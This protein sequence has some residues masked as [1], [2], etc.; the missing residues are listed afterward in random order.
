MKTPKKALDK[1]G[2]IMLKPI[3]IQ[4][5]LHNPREPGNIRSKSFQ[6]PLGHSTKVYITP[7][8]REIDDS[9]K[10]LSEDQRGCRLSE[11]SEELDV[12]NIYSQEA[13]HLECMIKQAY[14]R[15][16]CFPWNYLITTK[17]I[18]VTI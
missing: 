8:A 18:I 4:V 15:C 10:D 17:V 6:I 1:M 3:N 2:S 7:K 5:S 9:G 12:H 13:C 11:D 14:Q 16:G